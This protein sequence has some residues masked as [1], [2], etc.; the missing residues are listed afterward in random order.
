MR[1]EPADEQRAPATRSPTPCAPRC[2]ATRFPGRCCSSMIEARSLDLAG[3]SLADDAALRN[4]PVEK[5]G[6]AVRPGRAHPGA[7]TTRRRSTRPRRRS[8]Q[9]YGLARLLL[10][11]PRAR[12]RAG[13]CRCRS[14][15][16]EAAG[17]APA[18]AACRRAPD[19]ALPAC[20]PACATRS[21]RSLVTSR[22]H[23]ANLPRE[24][25][26]GL[27]SFGLGRV[28]SA[29]AGTAG[30]RRLARSRRDCAAHARAED[31][32]GAIGSAASEVGERS[33]R[34]Q[35]DADR[36]RPKPVPRALLAMVAQ[37][38]RAPRRSRASSGRSRTPSASS[39]TRPTRTCT[40][41]P[42]PACRRPSAAI[43]CRRPS[44]CSASAIPTAGPPRCSPTPAGTPGSIA[45]PA[46]TRGDYLNPKSHTILARLEGLDDA[47]TVDCAWLTSPQG[48]GP[49]GKVVTLPCDTPVQLEV[50]YPNGAWISVEIGGRQVAETAARVTDLFI[51]GMGDSFASGEGNPDVPVRFSP[52]RTTDYGV[53]SNS[54]PLAGYPARIGDWH[55]D[56]RPEIHRGE[57]ALAGPGLPSLALLPPAEGGAADR[58]RGPAPGRDVR[59]RRLLGRGDHVRPVPASTR[60]TSGCRTRPTCRRSRPSPRPSAAARARATTTCP[61]PTTSTRGSPSS[62]AAW[63]SRSA[64]PSARARSTCCSCRSA[65]TTSALP[66]WSPTRCWPTSR[67][68][69]A[70]AAGSATCTASPRPAPSSMPSTTA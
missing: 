9:A 19:P 13:G 56:R 43:P 59:R 44:G 4:L 23:V 22:Q 28:L 61:R 34:E 38:P 52:D 58:R 48:R 31:C 16:L 5:R 53:G 50:P 65:A 25:A 46:A 26:C 18:G 35:P 60:A 7:R 6:R 49:R 14:H 8:G 32:G 64:T 68:C 36:C 15:A 70:S 30:A 24:A 37:L 27:P 47:Q 45:T 33:S 63:C 55:D 17:V 40:A 21:A 12:C 11:L 51:V 54:A 2:D 41:R 42:G 3:E 10:G 39:S 57:R 1:C 29:G 62:R 69:A 67:S 20:S 66:G